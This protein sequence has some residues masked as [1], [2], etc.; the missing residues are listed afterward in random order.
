M[1]VPIPPG[2]SEMR[3]GVNVPRGIICQRASERAMDG[4]MRGRRNIIFGH[5]IKALSLLSS[6][7][8]HR[9]NTSTTVV[10]GSF[11]FARPIKLEWI[12]VNST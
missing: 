3:K 4:W 6:F 11:L 2:E 8:R 5:H 7:L 10:E 12:V 1:R 9:Q